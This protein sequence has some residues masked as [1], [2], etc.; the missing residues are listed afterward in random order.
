MA[1]R[2]VSQARA[3]TTVLLA[4]FT[5]LAA[6]TSPSVVRPRRIDG[7]PVQRQA[8]PVH[9]VGP[10]RR[11]RRDEGPL[12]RQSAASDLLERLLDVVGAFGARLEVRQ[13]SAARAPLPCPRRRYLPQH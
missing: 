5:E 12:D 7:V 8:V 9:L 3:I 11:G 1:A 13:V 10:P 2:S 6:S 4:I